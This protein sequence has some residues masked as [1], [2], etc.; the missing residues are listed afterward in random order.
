MYHSGRGGSDLAN[1]ARIRTLTPNQFVP[2]HQSP[3]ASAEWAFDYN[4]VKSYGDTQQHAED[5][6]ADRDCEVWLMTGPQLSPIAPPAHR[7]APHE[8][9]RQ[10]PVYGIFC[11]LLTDAISRCSMPSITTNSGGRLSAI[12]KGRCRR[13]PRHGDV[14]P[15]WQTLDA[16]PPAPGDPCAHCILSGAAAELIES[17][18][19]LRDFRRFRSRVRTAPE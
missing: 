1:A 17:S 4:E 5:S 2:V 16:T 12:R 3:L 14:R 13:Q 10:R 8:T 6:R 9:R 18:G 19:G 11:R 7:G 15:S